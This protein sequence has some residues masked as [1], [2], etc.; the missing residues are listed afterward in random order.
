MS[1][2]ES[3][4]PRDDGKFTDGTAESSADRLKRIRE[5][6]FSHLTKD[7]TCDT[8]DV[9]IDELVPCLRNLSTG[10]LV[11]TEVDE[12]PRKALKEYT[13]K[14]GWGADWSKR[15]KDEKVYGVYLKG[16]IR[17]QGLVS[18]RHDKGGVYVGFMCVAPE[19]NK[20]FTPSPRYAGIGGHLFAL[21]VEESVR[22]GSGGAVY[23]YAANE[24]LLQH[25]VK[26]FGA[27]FLGIA[28]QY[29]FIIDGEASLNLLKTYNYE[30]KTKK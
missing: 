7:E 18:L 30:R 6:Y 1:F 14:D 15:P 26:N 28:H 20:Q 22:S 10:Q 17:P 19:N 9:E 23:G 3:K 29:Q 27:I 8:L 21:A 16:D 11:D 24:K 25:Y 13:K 4:H 5:E 12:V 2:D